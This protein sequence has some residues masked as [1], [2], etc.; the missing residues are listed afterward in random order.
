LLIDQN[1]NKVVQ[2]TI[3]PVSIFAKLYCIAPL[4]IEVLVLS[5]R[6]IFIDLLQKVTL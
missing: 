2:K 5:L 4:F 3:H 6:K 1:W